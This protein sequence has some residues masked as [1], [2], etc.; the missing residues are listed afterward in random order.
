MISKNK[1]KIKNNNYN[2]NKYIN[3]YNEMI[4]KSKDNLI[5]MKNLNYSCFN[6]KEIDYDNEEKYYEIPNDN[7]QYDILKN[8]FDL[9][10]NKKLIKSFK[11]EDINFEFNL[12][13]RKSILLLKSYNIN[14][15]ILFFENKFLNNFLKI[16][17]KKTKILKKKINKL[18]ICIDTLEIKL[19]NLKHKK[20]SNFKFIEAL[21]N[22][23]NFQKE[24]LV[25]FISIYQNKEK[26]LKNLIQK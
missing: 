4:N 13:I 1:I 16:F 17:L 21:I 5:K 23:N 14:I 6:P 8:D 26:Y 22:Q 15:Q 20:E 10:Y 11:N 3:K 19:E 2:Y 7:S 25:D 12:F 9:F 24:I 18:S